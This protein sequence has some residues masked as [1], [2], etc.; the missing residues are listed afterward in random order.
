[1][2]RSNQLVPA[3][4]TDRRCLDCVSGKKR[5]RSSCCGEFDKSENPGAVIQSDV[6]G[7]LPPS[8]ALGVV[9]S[10]VLLTNTQGMQL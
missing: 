5:A 1:M 2:M 4:E 9:I 10:S 8:L 7:P 6:L 3:M